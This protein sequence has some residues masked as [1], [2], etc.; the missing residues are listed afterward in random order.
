[1]SGAGALIQDGSGTLT[2]SNDNTYTGAT[3]VNGG[4]LAV[5]GSLGSTSGV[6]VGGAAPATGS[7]TLTGTGLVNAPVT[8]NGNPGGGAAGL[9]NPGGV[10]TIGTLTVG[11]IT[12]NSGGTFALDIDATRPTY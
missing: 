11:S 9:I 7:P 5:T 6:A 1:M 10:G 8:I 3:T 4:I 12:F 2:L